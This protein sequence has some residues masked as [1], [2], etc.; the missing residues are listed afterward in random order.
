[1]RPGRI[2]ILPTKFGWVFLTGSVVMIL[3]GAAYQNNLVNLLAFFM[4]S[5]LFVAMVQTHNNLKDIQVDPP[6]TTNGFAGQTFLLTAVAHNSSRD[7]RFNLEIDIP[8]ER[9]T[10]VYE[11]Q[12]PL[13]GYSSVKLRCS[14]PAGKRGVY[15]IRRIRL[16][17]VFPLGLFRAFTW[18]NTDVSYMI[19]PELK[20]TRPYPT[21]TVGDQEYNQLPARGGD[22]F[23]GHRKFQESD[24]PRHVDWKAFARGRPMMVK[25]FSEGTP[26]ASS[27]DW[28]TLEGLDVEERLSQLAVWVEEAKLRH[29]QFSLRLPAAVIPPGHGY[30]H[31]TRCL[32]ALASHDVQIPRGRDEK[33]R[34]A[35]G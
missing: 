24:S 35:V 28:F 9:P 30:Q 29:A 22:D 14:Y 31:A 6:E 23:H 16:S 8:K 4:L 10:S 33:N 26:Q 1:M 17:T 32:E 15:Q 27:F 3:V 2:Y 18:I 7:P 20:G 25:E 11:N 21:G 34:K 12:H 5:L 13:L 19:Y